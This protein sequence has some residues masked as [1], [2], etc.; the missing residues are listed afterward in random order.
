MVL[1][2]PSSHMWAMVYSRRANLSLVQPIKLHLVLNRKATS[3]ASAFAAEVNWSSQEMSDP[4][5]HILAQN[6][7][8]IVSKV[9]SGKLL[10]MYLDSR[11]SQH[12]VLPVL[13]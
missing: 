1:G 12:C 4:I 9:I 2:S 10:T 3:H 8:D 7:N 5:Q 13:I 6:Y 11:I